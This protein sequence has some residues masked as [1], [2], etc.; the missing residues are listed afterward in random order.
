MDRIILVCVSL[1]LPLGL[2]IANKLID[3]ITIKK[4]DDA[5]QS[6]TRDILNLATEKENAQRAEKIAQNTSQQTS[7][8]AQQQVD[9]I[10]ATAP[11][12]EQARRVSSEADAIELARKQVEANR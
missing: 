6:L 3:R 1:F 2:F 12:A 5:I 4:K 11:L 7:T 10:K 9:T 8:L